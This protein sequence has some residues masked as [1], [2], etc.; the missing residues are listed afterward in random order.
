MIGNIPLLFNSYLRRKPFID[1]CFFFYKKYLPE[2]KIYLTL[3]D[4]NY[5]TKESNTN[6]LT[7][8]SISRTSHHLYECHSRYY[9]HYFTLNYL[10][11]LGYK[12]VMNCMDDGWINKIN[13]NTFNKSIQL[14]EKNNADRIDICGPQPNYDLIK[15]NDDI[16]L[17]NKNNNLPWYLTNQC[18]IWK[19]EILF[20]IYEILGPS[21]DTEVESRG[22]EIA[23]NL[24]LKFLTF[25][26]PVI[27]NAGCFRRTIGLSE[28]GK[29]LLKQYCKENNFDYNRKLNEFN[30]FI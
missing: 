20:K 23:R 14:L 4:S 28:E 19:I 21:A 16:S 17:I 26:V 22:S 1:I 9:R 11:T 3:D 12:Y 8:D 30:S 2:A 7:Y 13:Y 27:D 25:N 5:D 6:I 15:I 29:E 24:N 10:K 18:S